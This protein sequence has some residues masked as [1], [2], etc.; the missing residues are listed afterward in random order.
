MKKMRAQDL[1][2]VVQPY[3]PQ[4]P[5]SEYNPVLPGLVP[6]ALLEHRLLS[7]TDAEWSSYL[8]RRSAKSGGPI[9]TGIPEID[10]LEAQMF[11]KFSKKSG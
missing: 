7:L 5:A 4:P 9:E 1:W 10:A 6:S 8:T 3:L 11:E 2:S